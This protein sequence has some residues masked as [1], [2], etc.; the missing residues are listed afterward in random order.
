M[1]LPAT[2]PLKNK[3]YSSDHSHASS[4]LT[5]GEIATFEIQNQLSLNTNYKESSIS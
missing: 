4:T 3:G 2:L 5:K 1:P